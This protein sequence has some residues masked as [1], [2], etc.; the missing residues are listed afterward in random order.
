MTQ[1]F[2][3]SILEIS[4]QSLL[5]ICCLLICILLTGCGGGASVEVGSVSGIVT[6]DG[7]PL[8]GASITFEPQQGR[9]ASGGTD[10]KGYYSLSYSSN[11]SGAILGPCQVRITTAFEDEE[12]NVSPEKVPAKYLE[13]GSLNADVKS[14]SNEFNF[15]LVSQ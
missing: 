15:D 2:R 13:P 6:L 3:L 4:R 14:G 11:Q 1:Q 8:G 9:P 5:R 10:E 7:S 12:G